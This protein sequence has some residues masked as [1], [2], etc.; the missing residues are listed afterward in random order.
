MTFERDAIRRARWRIGLTVGLAI[1]ILLT[2]L[3]TISYEVL[4]HSQEQQI[5]RE[6]DYGVRHGAIDGPPACS[7]VFLYDANG[8]LLAG[9]PPPPPGLPI[10]AD[11]AEV[12][13]SGIRQTRQIDRNRT[14][15]WVRTQYRTDGVVQVVFDARFQ[16]ADRRHLLMAFGLA[17]LAGLLAAALT[18][19]L[20]GRRAVAPLAEAL[21]RQRRFVADASHELRTPIVQVHTRAQMLAR[22]A[23]RTGSEADRRDLD[24]L[25]GTTSRL[26]EIVEE[27]LLSA[28]MAATPVDGHAAGEVDLSRL[29][30]DAVA[31]ETDRAAE[32]G[33]AL[34]L[35]AP[36]APVPV[37]GI[38][39]ALRRVASELLANALTHTPDGG[40]ITVT[41]G[42]GGPSR[43][44]R[45]GSADLTV[46]DTG[47]GFDP[48]DTD[49]LFDRFH[50][51][52]G[53]GTR[54][55]GLGLA[56][57]H[58]V[59]TSHGGTI[60]ASTSPGLGATFTV[61]LPLYTP[62]PTSTR[63]RLF[64]ARA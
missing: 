30:A 1:G 55:F 44:F 43:T 28:R 51:G 60:T 42:T 17:G 40:H 34:D 16:L 6:L 22:R 50:R 38:E 3:G 11:V 18:A 58:E 52:S 25:I 23:R 8:V 45:H 46:T 57:L 21:G 9:G 26:G 33:V 14:T 35:I 61:R 54:R 20:V 62:T 59:V 29:C 36:P 49:R 27:L 37:T 24:R 2:L 47:D 39:S 12:A 64:P 31:A 10:P 4:R 56:L 32:H 7:W 19:V 15:Y 13:A 53:A 48:T 5:D 63:H 41:V